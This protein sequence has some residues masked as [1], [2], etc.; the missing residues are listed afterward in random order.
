MKR[1]NTM[2][3]IIN[4]KW[5]LPLFLVVYAFSGFS[6]ES[7]V[8]GWIQFRGAERDGISNESLSQFDCSKTQPEL[9]WKKNIGSA[10]SELTISEGVVYTMVSEVVDSLTGTEYLAAFSEE[11]GDEIWKTKVDSIYFDE[12]GW[13]NG[14]R[15]TPSIDDKYIFS[16]S[17][18]GKLTANL[19][20]DGSFVWQVDFVKEFGS[21]TPRWGFASSPLLLNGKVIMEVGGT[22]SRAFM[23]FNKENGDIVW[24][25]SNGAASHDSPLLAT[26]EG[27]EQIIFANGRT[28]YSLIPEGDT[29]WTYNMPFGGATAIPILIPPNKLFL[30]AVRNPGFFVVKVENNKAS[31]VLKGVSMKNDFSS[32]VYH[33]GYIYGFHVAA[34]RCISAETGEVKWTKR[35]YGK[36]SLILVD[37]KLIILS[38]KGKLVIADASPD[39]YNE[40]CSV[41]AIDGKS[42]TAPSFYNGKVFVRNLTE[43]AS[44]KLID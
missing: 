18:H 34:V 14:T 1:K 20:K 22:E 44:Y 4:Y 41:Q 42:W 17:G 36:G 10:F 15:S 24:S 29:L 23:A 19:K 33:E 2:K 6:Q 8:D 16:F 11:T 35:G 30:S 25:S 7:K 43:M 13:G 39:A 37:D 28:L 21:K 40:N 5:L 3:T 9:V 26:I 31:E 38:D 27:Q 12:D 32:C